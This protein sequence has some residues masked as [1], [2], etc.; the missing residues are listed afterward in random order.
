MRFRICYSVRAEIVDHDGTKI[1]QGGLHDKVDGFACHDDTVLNYAELSFLDDGRLRGG[2]PRLT[3]DGRGKL[4]I[5]VEVDA[6]RKLSRREIGELRED[7]EGQITDGIGAGCFDAL[8]AETGLRVQPVFPLKA[9][10]KQAEGVAWKPRATSARGN[11][12]RVQAAAKW[13]EAQDARPTSPAQPK[14][15]R[16]A[17]GKAQPAKPQAST[18][19]KQKMP[20]TSS[21][22]RA[23]PAGKKP[24]LKKLFRLLSRVD[25]DQIFP[26]IKA[27][28]EAR[29]NDLRQVEDRE[30]PYL[31]F[32]E[33]KLLRLLLK[34]GL[35]PDILDEKG[36]PLLVAAAI[37]AKSIEV[38]LKAGVDVN[39]V[40]DDVYRSTALI[41]AARLGVRK[42]VEV[43]LEH[44]ADPALTDAQGRTALDQL[45]PDAREFD[46]I[47]QMLKTR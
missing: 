13:V 33:P 28:L 7:L 31:N 15:K 43:L 1:D 16:T 39:Q 32:R 45:D 11:A 9:T 40:G 34:A 35:R 37:N 20:P 36:Y 21:A 44:G 41:E 2:H 23:S 8:A 25:R 47:E 30:L 19:A 4:C 18:K 26:Q 14:G 27:E 17:K 5:T 24:N 12:R 10:C 6:A 46:R 42:S 38:L 29:G 3:R 22:D